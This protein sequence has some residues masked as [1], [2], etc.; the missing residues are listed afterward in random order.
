MHPQAIYLSKKP[1]TDISEI[2]S[3]SLFVKKYLDRVKSAN[4]GNS[5][6]VARMLQAVAKEFCPSDSSV[7]PFTERLLLHAAGVLQEPKDIAVLSAILV[8]IRSES[9]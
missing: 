1:E 3:E 2:V 4:Q 9:T 8:A 5:L 6:P 7:I